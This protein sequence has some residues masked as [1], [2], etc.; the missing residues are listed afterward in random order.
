MKK[1]ILTLFSLFLMRLVYSQQNTPVDYSTIDT[2]PICEARVFKPGLI[3]LPA[4]NEHTC[5]ISADGSTIYFTRDPDRKIFVMSKT[6]AGWEQP[7]PAAFNGR[8][9]ILSPDGNRML[10]GDG[11]IWIS[12]IDHGNSG[13]LPPAIN[14]EAYEFYASIT[15]DGKI[16]FSR[17]VENGTKIFVSEWINGAYQTARQLP[18]PVNLPTSNNF[19]PFISAN[20]DFLI[21]NSDRAGGFGGADLYISYLDKEGK[22]EEPINLGE[23][24]NT[25]LRDICPTIT[26]D[27]KYLFFTRNWK[28]GD[29]WLG[30]LYWI[31]TDFLEK[32]N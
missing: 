22:W 30:D 12:S 11:D 9:G 4:S 10:S 2:L 3:S 1:V 7:V 8:E 15:N 31:R 16:F 29:Q 23:Q 32:N 19:H 18:E 27:G 5:A 25:E 20:G 17:F 26:L 6:G 24:I 28:E 14:T 13:K 21:F